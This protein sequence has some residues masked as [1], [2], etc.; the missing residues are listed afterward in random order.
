MDLPALGIEGACISIIGHTMPPPG[1]LIFPSLE[2]FQ[3]FLDASEEPP[4]AGEPI[5]FETTWLSLELEEKSALPPAMQREIDEAGWKPARGGLC[6]HVRAY[7]R[8]LVVRPLSDRDVEIVRRCAVGLSTFVAR[9]GAVFDPHATEPVSA[10]IWD[11]DG[12]EIRLTAPY[13]AYDLFEVEQDEEDASVPSLDRVVG[14][15][16]PCPCG[17][18]RK[19][20]KCHMDEHQRARALRARAARCH[21]L[22][23]EVFCDL[24]EHA[25]TAVGELWWQARWR[26]REVFDDAEDVVDC[27]SVYDVPFDG[28][29]VAEQV[30]SGLRGDAAEWLAAQRSSW[31]SLWEVQEVDDDCSLVLLDLLTGE[32]RTVV[33][34]EAARTLEPGHVVLCRVVDFHGLSIMCWPH[35]R[36]LGPAAAAEVVRR[37]RKRLRRKSPA[38]P[39]RLRDAEFSRYLIRAW[40]REVDAVAAEAHRPPRLCNTDG[41]PVLLTTD[42]FVI[43]PGARREI[44][45]RLS[46]LQDVVPP[47]DGEAGEEWTFLDPEQRIEGDCVMTTIRGTLRFDG[48]RLTISTNSLNRADALRARIERVCSGLLDH[49]AREHTDPVHALLPPAP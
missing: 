37:A 44:E 6:P 1:F 4:R 16:D 47:E 49:R 11:D 18:G 33:D 24:L 21:E 34:T 43:R 2:G 45:R 48:D 3:A 17:S 10:T 28:R 20:K 5:D 30:S 35:S 7:E 14:R 13:N 31:F 29:T 23:N 8:D 9:Y 15:N 27:W 19:Y 40:Q 46:Q 25:E 12:V 42:H 38:P 22:D 41:D 26:L 36:A 39:E 32:R